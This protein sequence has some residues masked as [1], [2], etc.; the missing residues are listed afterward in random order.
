MIDAGA[1][2]NLFKD[3][4]DRFHAHFMQTLQSARLF[5]IYDPRNDIFA[6][7]DLTV[8]I[9]VLGQDVTAYQVD[10]LTI[11]GGGS[12]IHGDGIAA[13]GGIARLII[14]QTGFAD[15]AHR[16][17]EGGGDLKII[18]ADG[19]RYFADNRKGNIQT[20]FVM[21]GLQVTDQTGD[22]RQIVL[23]CRF[24]E[25]RKLFFHRGD[26]QPLFL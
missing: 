6:I 12:D 21:L 19:I 14:D 18:F 26:E 4:I 9:T 15:I 7:A 3:L 25:L 17:H 2:D 20:M 22:V 13:A 5:S 16:A 11:N 24:R 23:G 10:D 8:E 1:L